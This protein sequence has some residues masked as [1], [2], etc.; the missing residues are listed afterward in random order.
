MSKLIRLVF[1]VVVA[2]LVGCKVEIES[3]GIGGSIDPHDPNIEYFDNDESKRQIDEQAERSLDMANEQ[4][5]DANR[6]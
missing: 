3:G 4:H 6:R 5:G 1:P 2:S